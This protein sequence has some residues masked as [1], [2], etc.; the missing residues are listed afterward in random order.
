MF[1]CMADDPTSRCSHHHC[2]NKRDTIKRR[3]AVSDKTSTQYVEMVVSQGPI[4][5]NLKP[6]RR[7]QEAVTTKDKSGE[8]DHFITVYSTCIG[9]QI[10]LYSY[11]SP[12]CINLLKAK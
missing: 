7:G 12:F 10:N 1:V 11:C 6:E 2:V 8:F 4:I 5:L 3:E 9:N